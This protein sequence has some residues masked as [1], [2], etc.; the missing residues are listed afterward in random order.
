VVLL[1]VTAALSFGSSRIESQVST[2]TN[3]LVTNMLVNENVE[4]SHRRHYMYVSKE[5]SDRTNGHLWTEKVVETTVGKLRMLIAEDGKPLTQERI[6]AEKA[7]LGEI[8]ANPD[9]FNREEL[10]RKGDEDKAKAMFNLLPKAFLFYNE[11]PDGGFVK[12]DFKPNP[13]YHPQS[14]EEKILHEVIGSML[15]DR[16]DA[17]LH[18]LEGHLPQDVNIGLGFLATIHAGSKFSTTRNLVPGKEWKT[19]TIDTNINGRALFFKSISQNEHAEHSDFEQ[20]SMN[21]TL[22]QALELLEK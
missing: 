16:K 15:V 14:M 11:R 22:A 12:I 8:A 17:R 5:I 6:A 18:L 20:V 21:V 19:A 2:S 3:D 13:S 1:A 7:R 4:A 10:G 9:K